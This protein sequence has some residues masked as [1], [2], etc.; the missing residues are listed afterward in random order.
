MKYVKI[1]E[2]AGS[3]LCVGMTYKLEKTAAGFDRYTSLG[4]LFTI[5][6]DP[7]ATFVGWV[8][9]PEPTARPKVDEMLVEFWQVVYVASLR[10]G[11]KHGAVDAD[12]ALAAFKARLQQGRFNQETPE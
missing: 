6:I 1:T 8:E 4:G 7:D 9:V 10:E 2:N 5:T 3:R 11:E 12:V